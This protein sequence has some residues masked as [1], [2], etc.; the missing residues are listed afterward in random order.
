MNKPECWPDHLLTMDRLPIPQI[1]PKMLSREE[2]QAQNVLLN[3]EVARLHGV[4][5]ALLA[6][7][8]DSEC[9]ICSKIVCPHGEPLHFHHDGCP[10]CYTEE[11]KQHG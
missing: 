1:L 7:C 6:H 3:A 9:T 4:A 11:F 2:L 5:D 8:P 10:S